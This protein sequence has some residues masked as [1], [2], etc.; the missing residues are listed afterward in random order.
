MGWLKQRIPLVFI[1]GTYDFILGTLMQLLISP[2]LPLHTPYILS[3]VN[4]APGVGG[5]FSRLGWELQAT[6]FVQSLEKP[7]TIDLHQCLRNSLLPSP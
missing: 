7:G 5:S 3:I 6:L 2:T 4:P 1:S